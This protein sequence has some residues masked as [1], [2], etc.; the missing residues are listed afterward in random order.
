MHALFYITG[1]KVTDCSLTGLPCLQEGVVDGV[2]G[3]YE[4]GS[5]GGGKFG[6]PQMIPYEAQQRSPRM[7]VH[8]P[9]P[10][11]NSLLGLDAHATPAA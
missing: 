8:C 9:R 10:V 11:V 1:L 4:G 7:R 3:V 2:D 5:K 6:V